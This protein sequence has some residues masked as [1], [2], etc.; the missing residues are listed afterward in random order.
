MKTYHI[1]P[2]CSNWILRMEKP[3]KTQMS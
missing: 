1:E 3:A 2:H